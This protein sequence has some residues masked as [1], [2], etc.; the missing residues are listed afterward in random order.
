MTF[1]LYPRAWDYRGM[2]VGSGQTGSEISCFVYFSSLKFRCGYKTAQLEI[3]ATYLSD[4][5]EK[6][7]SPASCCLF[8]TYVSNTGK[9][10]SFFLKF[11]IESAA[12]SED[13]A[14]SVLLQDINGHQKHLRTS[15]VFY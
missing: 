9:F 11:S 3:E 14:G 12:K 7:E 6:G 10:K 2:T 4:L 5:L 13:E 15:F 1:E 8:H